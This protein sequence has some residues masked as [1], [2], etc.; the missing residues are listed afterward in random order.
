LWQRT[1][2]PLRH[3]KFYCKKAKRRRV[4]KVKKVKQS[5][6]NLASF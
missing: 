5:E 6:T 3:T 2:V 1:G 4:E